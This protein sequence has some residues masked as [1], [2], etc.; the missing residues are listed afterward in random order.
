MDYYQFDTFVEDLLGEKNSRP[1][2][3]IGASRI[4]DL[5]YKILNKYFLPKSSKKSDSDELLE[6]DRPLATF[7]SRIKIAYRLGIIDDSLYKVLERIR[8]IRNKSA[9]AIEFDLK[10]SPIRE[11]VNELRKNMT[12]R[13]AYNKT[14]ERYF[15]HNNLNDTLELQC[16]MIT[17]CVLLE[18]IHEKIIKTVGIK[19]T[20]SIS[21]K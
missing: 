21:N 17:I 2:V 3:I 14:A 9:H 6:G 4:D 11:H 7:S 15:G 13:S 1:I 8:G 18:A 5:L 12:N 16:I 19:E 10:K 20:I